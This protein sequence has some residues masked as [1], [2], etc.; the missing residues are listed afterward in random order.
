MQLD[1]KFR[2]IRPIA[3]A[4]FAASI[5]QPFSSR[6]EAADKTLLDALEQKGVI[7]R[8]EA[9]AIAKESAMQV[10]ARPET[11]SFRLSSRFQIQYEWLDSEA[12]SGGGSPA[13]GSV[14]GF[15]VRRFFLQ[16]D[17]DLGGG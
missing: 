8:E 11:K 12:Y 2:R 9:A 15:N 10:S 1:I 4:L 16:A 17:A 14:N 7:T 13:Y 5:L 6:S 3:L